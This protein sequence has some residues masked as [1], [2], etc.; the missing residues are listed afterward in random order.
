MIKL[1]QTH[2]QL[3]WNNEEVVFLYSHHKRTVKNRNYDNH[4]STWFY[5]FLYHK[6]GSLVFNWIERNMSSFLSNKSTRV[7]TITHG[8]WLR[9]K[10]KHITLFDSS[11]IF[12]FHPDMQSRLFFT[13]YS[14]R[15]KYEEGISII[16]IINKIYCWLLYLFPISLLLRYFYMDYKRNH[17]ALLNMLS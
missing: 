17:L 15:E 14:I 12:Q 11:G 2:V 7:V 1:P 16:L 5:C 13:L 10:I 8:I 4:F 9:E 3:S 6:N